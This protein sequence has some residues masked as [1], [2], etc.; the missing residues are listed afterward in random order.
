MKEWWQDFFIPVT[1]EIMFTPKAALSK[2]E[3]EQVIAQ[4]KTPKHAQVLDLACGVGRHSVEFAK[5][6]FEVIG[7]D[8]SKHYLA[9]AK[10]FWKRN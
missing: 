1:G 7:L 9:E 10:N 5:K 3:V 8:F 4:T 2:I 6:N